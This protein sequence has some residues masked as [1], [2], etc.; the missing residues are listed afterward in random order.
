MKRRTFIQSLGLLSGSAF[1][2]LNS[3]ALSGLRRSATVSGRVTASGRGIANVAVSDGYSVV[4]TDLSGRYT[5]TP[6]EA[7]AFIFMSTPAGYEFK[8]DYNLASQ[9]DRLGSRNEYDFQLTRLK[10]ND[11]RHNF[12]VWADPQIK[13]K[14]DA[15]EMMETSVPDVQALVKSMG[16]T[17]VHG[18]AVGDLVWDNHA[19]FAD[20]NEAVKQMGIPFFQALGNHD[21]DYRQGGDETSDKTFKQNYGPTYYSFNRGKAHYV[22]FDDVR[23][24]GIERTY[25]GYISEQQLSWLEQDLKSVPTENLLFICLHIPVHNAVKNNAALYSLLKHYKN[26]HILSG[27]THYSR[28]VQISENIF[29]HNH[30]TVCGAWWTGPVCSDGCPRG[31]GV[32]EVNGRDVKWY[33][34]GTG[35]PKTHQV[36]L[37]VERS[38][39]QVRLIANVWN[40]DPKWK[41][42]YFADGKAM[43]AME[44]TKG[45]DP[46]CVRMYKGA[47]MP[48][49]RPFV[50]PHRTE[51]LFLAQLPASVRTVEILV[52][53]RFGERYKIKKD[54]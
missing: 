22:V 23:Y 41:V 45:F 13:T 35:Q 26:V 14:G 40:Y 39:K 49:K 20:Y 50:E 15:K 8:T 32:Y 29:E 44:M 12:I 1:I 31:Y 6:N 52:T 28:N 3:S 9:Y 7:A 16:N 47:D 54:V 30:G 4:L 38:E 21:M 24:L 2:S 51:H 25:D 48:K 10:R 18:I 43:G 34:K 11:D 46:E 37:D 5:I 33:Y 36:S 42:E 27:H 17:P 19:L 53:D